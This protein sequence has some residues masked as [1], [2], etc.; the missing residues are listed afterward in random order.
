M[1][2]G[3][4]ACNQKNLFVMKVGKHSVTVACKNKRD[5]KQKAA[6]AILKEIHPHINSWG[7]L[8]RLYG[9]QSVKSFKE[10][11]MEEQQITNLQS[12]ASVNSPNHAILDKLKMEMLKLYSL[13][14]QVKPI[15]VFRPADNEILPSFSSSNLDQVNL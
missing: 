12:K 1:Y 6:Q 8:L 3:N 15:G 4:N 9:S 11:K 5:G 2:E 13:D 14:T 7:S 10:K